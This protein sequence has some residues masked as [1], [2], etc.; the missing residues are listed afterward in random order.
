VNDGGLL[1]DQDEMM[2]YEKGEMGH[3]NGTWGMGQALQQREMDRL[4]KR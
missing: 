1:D 2:R 3:V 4:L